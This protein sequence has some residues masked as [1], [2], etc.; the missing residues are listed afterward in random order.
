MIL[1]HDSLGSVE[2]W[3]DFPENLAT[4]TGWP[5]VAYDRLGFGKSD[6]HPGKLQ[7]N[8]IRDEADSGLSKVIA[9]LGVREMI[10][11]SP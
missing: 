2:L 6:A 4:C 3:R 11:P 10:W 1:L 7:A 5:V 8:F 9:A